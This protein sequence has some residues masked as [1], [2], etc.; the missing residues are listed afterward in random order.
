MIEKHSSFNSIFFIFYLLQL[1]TDIYREALI[2]AGGIPKVA[3]FLAPDRDPVHRMLAVVCF[4]NLALYNRK[5]PPNSSL[6]SFLVFFVIEREPP[7]AVI[8]DLFSNC[9]INE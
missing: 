2:Q 9:S 6:L 3:E 7:L 4:G 5:Q 1:Q 8:R